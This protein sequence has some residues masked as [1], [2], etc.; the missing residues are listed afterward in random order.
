MTIFKIRRSLLLALILGCTAPGIIQCADLSVA[1]YRAA[2][3]EIQSDLDSGRLVD[4]QKKSKHLRA[5]RVASNSSSFA[6]DSSILAPIENSKTIDDARALSPR[7]TTQLNALNS[8][9]Q[10]AKNIR[11]PDPKLLD[12]L[13]RDEVF[14]LPPKDGEIDDS[15][16]IGSGY[17]RAFANAL[18]DGIGWCLK[19]IKAVVDWFWGL[20]PKP[21][22]NVGGESSQ[23]ITYVVVAFAAILGAYLL[24]LY[25]RTR[26]FRPVATDF[27]PV[28]A[29]ASSKDADP[30]SR[31]SDQWE[32]Y[33]V[34]LSTSGRPREAIRAW[35]HA[36]LVMF[37]RSGA[38]TYRKGRTN[39]EYFFALSA[40]APHRREFQELTGSFDA[41]WYGKSSSDPEVASHYGESAKKLLARPRSG[42]Q[43]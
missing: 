11:D 40:D 22:S 27:A 18:V 21:K 13:R 5:A 34:K 37:F 15:A 29:P 1:D 2:L 12:T 33:A 36:V 31:D 23:W 16:T 8:S 4:A 10:S 17:L 39:W 28:S 35:Y 19:K 14:V 6:T 26:K 38:L 41:E 32:E 42:G 9:P 30:L 3:S 25:F 7:I 20:F 24:R 43:A